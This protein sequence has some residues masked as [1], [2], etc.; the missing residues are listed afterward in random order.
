MYSHGYF[1]TC[2]TH[3]WW[4][5]ILWDDD[6]DEILHLITATAHTWDLLWLMQFP[7]KRY[8]IAE[9]FPCS[10]FRGGQV[11]CWT[12]GC[13][14]PGSVKCR[15]HALAVWRRYLLVP[16]ISL[17]HADWYQTCPWTRCVPESVSVFVQP[18]GRSS[19]ARP[20]SGR[21]A[22]GSSGRQARFCPVR[23]GEPG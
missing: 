3:F 15:S 8:G 12:H 19:R 21:S 11:L 10:L 16:F 23:V 6:L 17:H 14:V 18:G 1:T 7:Y 4:L 2:I 22:A 9:T 5:A 20:Q 13:L